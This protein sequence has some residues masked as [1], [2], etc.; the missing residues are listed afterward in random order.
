MAQ[1]IIDKGSNLYKELENSKYYIE[2]DLHINDDVFDIIN[3][4]RTSLKN[5]ISILSGPREGKNNKRIYD[6][7]GSPSLFNPFYAVNTAGASN[8]LPILDTIKNGQSISAEASSDNGNLKGNITLTDISDCSIKNLVEISNLTFE[9]GYHSVLGQA[10]YKWADFMYCKELGQISNN[11]MITLRRFPYPIFD[12]IFHGTQLSD[13]DNH[14][15]VTGDIGRMITWF[16]TEDNKLESIL[17]YNFNA[18]FKELTAEVQTKESE[19]SEAARGPLGRIVNLFSP[20]YHEATAQGLEGNALAQI[21][22]KSGAGQFPIEGANDAPYKGNPAVN[23]SIYDKNKI[24]EPKDTVRSTHTYDGNLKFNHEFNLVFNYKLRGYDNINTKTAF[25][26]LIANIL[27]TT[28]RQGTFWGGEQ[29]IL[30]APQNVVGWKKALEIRNGLI[31]GGSTFISNLFN[32]KGAKGSFSELQNAIGG[33]IGDTL[34][35]DLKGIIGNP[36]EALSNMFK[37][38]KDGGIGLGDALKGSVGNMLGRPAIYAFDSLLTNDAVGPWHVTIGNPLNPIAA[39]GNLIITDTQISHSGPLGLDDFPTDLKVEVKLKHATP[40]DSV[41]IQKM[42]TGGRNAIYSKIGNKANLNLGKF[43]TEPI[44][45]PQN[46]LK[47]EDISYLSSK[48]DTPS[49]IKTV[50]TPK[51]NNSNTWFND[52]NIERIYVSHDTIQK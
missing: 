47:N 38:G 8:N 23:G 14:I 6:I 52:E 50:K 15:T 44:Y 40:R 3:T 35:I 36:K 18:E 2:N 27:I 4:Y 17:S 28:Y 29:R 7:I 42:Y 12:N 25:L 1:T 19:E 11:Y 20:K 37:S 46:G 45:N 31:E 21:L 16:G 41:D 32:G 10:R 49:T 39:F 13:D 22:E 24:Y 43:S 26:D 33:L 5:T 48:S 30:G 9:N 34:G 51:T